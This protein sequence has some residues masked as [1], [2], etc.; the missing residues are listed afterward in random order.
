[1]LILWKPSCQKNKLMRTYVEKCGTL[2]YRLF[3]Y[4]LLIYNIV[5]YVEYVER[6]DLS[7]FHF[8]HPKK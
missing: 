2:W 7:F 1:M 5:E 8:F 3:I 4:N 6:N